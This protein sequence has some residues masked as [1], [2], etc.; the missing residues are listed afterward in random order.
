MFNTPILFLIFN[1]PNTTKAVFESIRA[2]KP[3]RLYVAADG[4][5]TDKVGEGLLVQ[6]TRAILNDIDWD[7]EVKTLFRTENL[8]CKIAVSSA[9]DWFFE[10]EEQGIILEDDCLPD[11][12]FYSYCEELLELYKSNPKILHIGGVNFQNGR[13]RGNASYY[14][15]SYNHVWGWASWR[16]AWYYYDVNLKNVEEFELKKLLDTKLSCKRERRYWKYIYNMVILGKIGTW[17]Y[18]WLFSIWFND[19]VCISPNVNLIKNIGFN[20]VG[21]HTVGD[22]VLGL[23]NIELNSLSKLIHPDKVVIDKKA[24]SYVFRNFINPPF[25]LYLYKKLIFLLSK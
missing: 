9:I 14:F 3:L 18:Q 10:N 7:C 22:D 15:T 20:N 13:K 5:R 4:A 19:G 25:F 2:V 16:R 23:S 6:E 24:D 1:R 12:S 17:D 11:L 8:G 21:T